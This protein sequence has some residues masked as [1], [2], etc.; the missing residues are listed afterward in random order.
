MKKR[1]NIIQTAG[2]LL[3]VTLCALLSAGMALHQ[4]RRDTAHTAQILLSHV[5]RVTRIASEA[6]R[7]TAGMAERPCDEIREKMIATGALTPYLRSI[8][9]L[10]NGDLVCSSVTGSR[11][12][13]E[14]EIYGTHITANKSGTSI[15]SIDGTSSLPGQEAI[16]YASSAANGMTAISVV[17]ARYFIDLM[18]SLNDE[19]HDKINLQ[20]S[21]GPAILSPGGNF[22]N[23]TSFQSDFSSSLSHVRLRIETPLH[24]LIYYV[25]RNLIFLGPLFLLLTFIML[26]IEQRWQNREIS[27]EDELARGITQGEFSVHY[28]PLCETNSGLC[29]GAEALMRWQRRD[30]KNISPS[31]FIRAAEENGMIINLTQHLFELIIRD[32]KSWNVTVPFHLGVNIAAAHLNHTVFSNDVLRLRG[33]ID[34]F[35]NLVLE[36][37]ERSL[38]EDMAVAAEKLSTLRNKGC[39]VAV[40]DFGTGYCSLSLLQDLPVDYLKIDKSFID[41]LSSAGE[42]TPILDMIIA[43]SQRLGLTTIG[44]GIS[45]AHQAE[46]LKAN[47]V[48]YVQGYFYAK[49]MPAD[50]FY[51]WYLEQSK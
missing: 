51:Q 21:S 4:L 42:D 46:W 2:A 5:D 38:V 45:T 12:L 43:L 10:L 6:S 14:L 28:Q 37:T 47:R 29:T 7:I 44:E 40:D 27:L 13:N 20:F 1:I 33:S 25:L 49:P 41:T 16:I 11:V 17:D 3:S 48:P 31:V 15:I 23:A 36:I 34:H 18:D 26:Y 22:T 19:N 32:V 30:G 8:G 35:F 50:V 39:K 24:S 9:L